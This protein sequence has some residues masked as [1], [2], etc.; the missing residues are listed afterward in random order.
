MLHHC[1]NVLSGCRM[2]TYVGSIITFVATFVRYFHLQ[3]TLSFC[4]DLS[5]EPAASISPCESSVKVSG[6]QVCTC[7]VHLVEEI[8]Y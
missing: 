6:N 3:W 8:D 2:A 1:S 7:T 5:R 4:V